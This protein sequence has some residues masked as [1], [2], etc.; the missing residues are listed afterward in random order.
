LPAPR[1]P[2]LARVCGRFTTT[3]SAEDL[4]SAFDALNGIDH[5]LEPDYNVAPTDP[6]PAVRIARH[7]PD[8]AAAAPHRQLTEFRWGLVPSWAGDRSGAARMI[9]ARAETLA[10]KPAYRAAFERRRCLVPADGWYEW[11]RNEHGPGKQPYY[12]TAADGGLLVFAGLWETWRGEQGGEQDG[13]QRGEQGGALWWSCSVVTTAAVGDLAGIHD[14]MPLVL[15]RDRWAAWLGEVP[16][17]PELLLAP[18]PPEVVAAIE[19]RPVGSA[20]GNV[21]NN[22]RHLIDPIAH[23]QVDVAPQTLF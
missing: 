6:V 23:P 19:L 5:L 8:G 16:A 4:T 22:G 14:R 9:N 10:D 21:R 13:E 12:L 2:I 3:R 11:R 20:V 17:D 7:T 15:P 1:L 18:T